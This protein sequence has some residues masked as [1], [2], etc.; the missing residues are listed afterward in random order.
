MFGDFPRLVNTQG[1]PAV[2]GDFCDGTAANVA[3]TV[4]AGQGAFVAGPNGLSVGCFA[5][6]DPTNTFLNSFGPG[7]PTGFFRRNQQGII[8]NYLAYAVMT[9]YPG[10]PCEIFNA[11]GFW[12][13]NSGT[14]TSA[15]GN[16]AY[17]NNSTGQISFGVTGSPP[18]SGSATSATVV[19]NISASTGAAIP[20]T[21]PSFTGSIAGQ[22]LTVTAIASG[23]VLGAGQVISGGPTANPVD[24]NTTITGFVSGTNGGVGVYTVNISQNVASGT[25]TASGGCMTLTGANTSGIFA[26][27]NALSVAASGSLTAGTTI[28]A[29]ISATAGGA[30][31]YLLNQPA[32]TAVTAG[33]ITSTNTSLLTVDSSSTGTWA[34]NDQLTGGANI[35][36]AAPYSYILATGATNPNLTGLGGAG[37]Y[38][39]SQS[40]TFASGT[41]TVDIGVET[42]WVASSIGAPGELVKMTSYL[43]G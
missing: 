7:L 41:V 28:T 8:T 37:T 34:I 42:K 1:A 13:L 11:G 32:A 19:K 24:P 30:G 6:A 5:W 15:I 36:S 38:L 2:L 20:A 40:Y 35:P 17:A 12:V 16:K 25:I 9:A 23:T 14:T 29:L 31:T 21:G 3:S 27:G 22:T 18:T 26:V 43:N 33:T 4:D 10:S 39:V